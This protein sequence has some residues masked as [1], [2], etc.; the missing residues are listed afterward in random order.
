MFTFKK[1]GAGIMVFVKGVMSLFNLLILLFVFAI[2][3]LFL[4]MVVDH[5]R[6][7]FIRKK[8]RNKK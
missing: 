2:G 8:E 6:I 5:I 4:V 3:T 1:I 7:F